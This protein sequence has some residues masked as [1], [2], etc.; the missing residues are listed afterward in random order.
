MSNNLRFDLLPTQTGRCLAISAPV[1]LMSAAHEASS[2]E[3]QKRKPI[4]AP[5]LYKY[6]L[7][8][9]KLTSTWVLNSKALGRMHRQDRRDLSIKSI[10]GFIHQVI[11]LSPKHAVE[12]DPKLNLLSY[13]PYY[14]EEFSFQADIAKPEAKAMYVMSLLGS[15]MLQMVEDIH[16]PS[17]GPQEGIAA[18]QV[19]SKRYFGKSGIMMQLR[20]TSYVHSDAREW[21]WE[22]GRLALSG[23]NLQNDAA[24]LIY[25]AGVVAIAHADELLRPITLAQQG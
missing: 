3:F 10:N 7:S 11:H 13:S 22:S 14:K 8:D 2:K 17:R 18:D 9:D 20:E 16:Y 5:P 25:L 19:T 15:T 1:E 12:S 4:G 23:Y 21:D 6:V 24:P